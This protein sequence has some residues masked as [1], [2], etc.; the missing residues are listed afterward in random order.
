MFTL[1]RSSNGFDPL[2]G[3]VWSPV[4]VLR[5][6]WLCCPLGEEL[7]GARLFGFAVGALWVFG[8]LWP[9][10]P[11]CRSLSGYHRLPAMNSLSI[12][13]DARSPCRFASLNLGHRS[14]LRSTIS[15][16][17]CSLTPKWV[18]FKTLELFLTVSRSLWC[19][20]LATIGRG[21]DGLGVFLPR[22]CTRSNWKECSSFM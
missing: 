18:P 22:R 13:S 17:N 15:R 20:N 11:P 21:L 10:C 16:G 3:D 14:F 8:A 5:L 6:S 2:V 1:S 12:T 4:S 9:S 19:T 7:L